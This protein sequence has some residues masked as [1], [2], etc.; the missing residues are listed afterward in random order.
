MFHYPDQALEEL[1]EAKLHAAREL[2]AVRA[3]LKSAQEEFNSARQMSLQKQNELQSEVNQLKMSNELREKDIDRLNHT[4]S[5]EKTQRDL[6]VQELQQQLED[7]MNEIDAAKSSQR[8]L[9]MNCKII[10]SERKNMGDRLQAR[11]CPA[12]SPPLLHVRLL[13]PDFQIAINEAERYKSAVANL[14][15][16]AKLAESQIS[17]IKNQLEQKTAQL[18][19][20]QV[21]K[22]VALLGVV[23]TF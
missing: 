12:S 7:A 20:A 22:R 8:S 18:D 19:E 14:E 11:A 21:R 13:T 23:V 5:S 15:T 2:Q 10:E 17:S 16:Q 9:E 4:V 6:K 1:A 3:D